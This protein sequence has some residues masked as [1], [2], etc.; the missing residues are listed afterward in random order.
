MVQAGFYFLSD[1]FR[2]IKSNRNTGQ[3]RSNEVT[4]QFM[5]YKA[6]GICFLFAQASGESIMHVPGLFCCLPDLF[7]GIFI[8]S[9][10]LM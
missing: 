2:M 1:D 10:V 3:Y 5:F 7:T 6:N 9:G 4:I 8:N